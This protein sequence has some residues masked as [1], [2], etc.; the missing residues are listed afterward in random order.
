M[1]SAG[2]FHGEFPAKACDLLSLAVTELCNISERRLERLLNPDTERNSELPFFLIPREKG[3][4]HS[5]M[6][7]TQ[8]T[9]AALT[10]EN[11]SRATNA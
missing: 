4:L 1:L 8:Y 3:G 5:G 10:S 2:N 11:R 6:M 9:A 7:I